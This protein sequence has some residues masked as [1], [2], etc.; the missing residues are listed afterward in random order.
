MKLALTVT[1]DD[2][3]KVYESVANMDSSGPVDPVTCQ[4]LLYG[5]LVNA[6]LT[7]KVQPGST[8]EPDKPKDNRPYD[9][10]NVSPLAGAMS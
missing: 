1:V 8:T 7:I 10:S 3:Q 9:M 2:K 6:L 4:W 5:M